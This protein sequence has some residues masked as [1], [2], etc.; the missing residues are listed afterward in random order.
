MCKRISYLISSVLVVFL[1]ST[2]KANGADPNLVGWWKFDETSGTTATDSSGSGNHGVLKGSPEWVSGRMNGAVKLRGVNDYIDLPIS[3]LL[4][5]LDDATLA[6][7]VNWSDLGSVWSRII[8]FGIDQSTC[9][10]VTPASG[11]GGRLWADIVVNGI[12]TPLVAP[13]GFP[14]GDWHHLAV[15]VGDKSAKTLRVYVDGE[16]VACSYSLWIL[17]ELGSSTGGWLGRSH[18]ATDPYFN[19]SLD[20][21]RIYNRMLSQVE[22][23][24]LVG[25][26]NVEVPTETDQRIP[27]SAPY[28]ITQ[29][30]SYI[31]AGDIQTTLADQNAI[32]VEANNVT[33]DLNG[34]NLN[35]PGSGNGCGIFMNGR[36]NVEIRNGTIRDF[37]GYGIIEQ[38]PT[39]V[40]TT[41]GEGHRIF[42][43]RAEFNHKSG[44]VLN[45]INNM[46]EDCTVFENGNYGI[47]VAGGSIVIGNIST[48]NGA[49]GNIGVGIALDGWCLALENIVIDNPRYGIWAKR[50]C[51]S[52]FGNL[53]ATAAYGIYIDGN[54]N[55]VKNN[56][57][58]ENTQYNIHVKGT[59]NAIEEN[60]VTGHSEYG[61]YFAS[62]GNFY[63]NNRASGNTTNY[64]GPGKPTGSPGDGGGN[65][66]F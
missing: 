2:N 45:G 15:V 24:Q 58:K 1:I 40:N 54:G 38:S 14:A 64:G 17:S 48:N 59:D 49:P 11:E 16:V 66:E 44:I 31:L 36:T 35:G 19:G 42:G 23:Q 62:S 33:I 3:S 43:I 60:L 28:T 47:E 4:E 55:F 18:F 41:L 37:G 51:S 34:F 26:V 25:G 5:T 65:I 57:A 7:W 61:I 29:P 52:V 56:T 10:Y 22:I 6:I 32:T 27:I 12:Q 8:D 53:V 13:K 39:Y 21:F 63:A 9:F 50:D 30:G 20:D 46:V